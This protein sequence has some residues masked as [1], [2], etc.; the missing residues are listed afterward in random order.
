M[1]LDSYWE[2]YIKRLESFC[3]KKRKYPK[4]I[5][6]ED[7][8]KFSCAGNIELYDA[9]TDKLQ[10]GMFSKRPA[11]PGECLVQ[12]REKFI[13]LSPE[14][15]AEIL[16]GIVA[17][18]GRSSGAG[19]DLSLL[20]GVPKAAVTTLSSKFSNWRK[21]FTTVRIIYSDASGLHETKSVNL[22]DLI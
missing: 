16:L 7:Y 12:G 22:L 13:A 15:Q 20:G 1:L 5:Y 14:Q 18:M 4:F 19:V 21:N 9:L 2:L 8:D 11:N 17:C 10:K 6:S 3:E